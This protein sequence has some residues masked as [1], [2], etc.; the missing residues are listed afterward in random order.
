MKADIYDD[1]TAKL[2]QHAAPDTSSSH[3][4]V[5]P[6][7]MSVGFNPYYNNTVRSVEVHIMHDF[8]VNFYETH[9][10]LIVLGFIRGEA[11]Y[12]TK[13]ALIDDIKTDIDV[14]G[15]SL[16]RREYLSFAKDPYLTEFS[17]RSEIAS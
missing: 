6:M 11:D 15:R 8:Q 12:T 2:Q 5:Y 3:G 9:M 13:E 10:N 7:V 14:S 17:G 1:L 16:G 4:A